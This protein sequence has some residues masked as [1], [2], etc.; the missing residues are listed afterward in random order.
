MN[1]AATVPLCHS[2]PN[3]GE[4]LGVGRTSMYDLIARGE[5]STITIGTRRLVPHDELVAYVER[6][7][8]EA[9]TA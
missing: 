7:R 1:D 9:L 5:I 8:S 6:R 2:I 3:A 4:M